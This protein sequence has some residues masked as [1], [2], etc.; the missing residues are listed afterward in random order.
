[1][2]NS[3]AVS[4]HSGSSSWEPQST[5]EARPAV[6]RPGDPSALDRHADRSSG[7]APD[8]HWLATRQQVDRTAG[9]VRDSSGSNRDLRHLRGDSGRGEERAGASVVALDRFC[10]FM[11]PH[12]DGQLRP[13]ERDR[14]DRARGN[15]AG[16]ART[17]KVI[18]LDRAVLANGESGAAITR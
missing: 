17:G 1:M 10:S 5:D 13:G 12:K 8:E 4:S 6:D 9:A 14:L 18:D 3:G 2:P 7:R 11:A 15:H 16:E